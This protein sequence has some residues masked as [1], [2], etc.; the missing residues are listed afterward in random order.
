MLRLYVEWRY[1][2]VQLMNFLC[3]HSSVCSCVFASCIMNPSGKSWKFYLVWF[4]RNQVRERL[5]KMGSFQPM[6][7]FLHQE[8]DRMQRVIVL[9]RNTLT[10]LMLAIDGTII[11]SQNLRDALDCMYDARIP[12]RWKKVGLK[13]CLEYYSLFSCWIYLQFIYRL[14]IFW[15]SKKKSDVLTASNTCTD[16]KLLLSFCLLFRWLFKCLL[17]CTR[18]KMTLPI[19]RFIF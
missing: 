2:Q 12:S 6:N 4:K 10:D 13:N 1:F 7:I 5:Q 17:S 19:G 9:V 18:G 3:Q 8:I 14:N 11:M 15:T 16:H